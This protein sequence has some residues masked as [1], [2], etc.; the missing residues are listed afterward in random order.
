MKR[1]LFMLIKNGMILSPGT[2][3]QY[4]AD[5]RIADGIITEIGRLPGGAC[6][7]A[8]GISCIKEDAKGGP[9]RYCSCMPGE[10]IIPFLISINKLRFI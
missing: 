7:T 4:R 3:E 8:D 1:S 5:I 6:P 10:R 9:A 2:Q